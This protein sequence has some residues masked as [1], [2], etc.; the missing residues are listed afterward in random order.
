MRGISAWNAKVIWA[1]GTNGTYLRTSD[2]GATWK[3][4]TV[5]GAEQ[6][7][8]R[9]IHALNDRIV[10]LLSSGP[11]E[12]SRIYKTI[13]AGEHWTLQY[14]NPGPQGFFDAV[15]FWDARHGIVLGD[16]VDGHF[17]V[18]TTEDGGE[19]W[20]QQSGPPAIGQEGAFAASNSCLLAVGRRDAWFA[21]GGLGGARV[22]HSKDAGR[23]WTAVSTPIRNDSASA[24]VFSIA[25]ADA[26]HGIAVGG[27][28]TKPADGTH[29]IA[30]TSDGGRAW[31][32]PTG[33]HP[34]GYRSAV[35]YWPREKAWIAV[36]TSGADISYDNGQTWKPFDTGAYN[37]LSVAGERCWAVGPN[38][39]LAFATRKKA[40][41]AEK[42][43][44][45]E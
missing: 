23:T 33:Q 1:S 15:A 21:T 45:R 25:F 40:A 39:R 42:R 29:N 11:G 7:D 20:H 44:N 41:S 35:I 2:G 8:F 24:G 6:L 3:G 16:P 13:D 32:E 31:T 10:Y 19:H 38:G 17:A 28:Y 37:A 18:L 26:R 30:V 12:K 36:G 9:G 14:K 4:A 22:F 43:P 5:P 34:A 27:D